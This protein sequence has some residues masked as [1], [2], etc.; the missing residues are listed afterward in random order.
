M[1]TKILVADD[2][3][4]ALKM[5][6]LI[7]ERQGYA[8]V[9]AHDG[10]EALQQVSAEMPDLIILDVMMPRLSGYEV[11]ARLRADPAT[12]DIPIIMFTAKALT[13][14]KVAGFEVGADDY[15]TKPTQPAELTARIKT[16]LA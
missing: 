5:T 11:C 8:V 3:L 6:C 1:A 15:L 9:I 16:L 13:N 12:A 10:V 7:L 4:G 14:D 2:D